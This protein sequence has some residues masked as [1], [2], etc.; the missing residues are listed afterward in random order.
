MKNTAHAGEAAS[1]C[2]CLHP[3]KALLRVANSQGP[4]KAK[5]SPQR[6]GLRMAHVRLLTRNK[7]WEEAGHVTGGGGG[8][9]G[10]IGG[11]G[12]EHQE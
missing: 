10:G 6:P 11:E 7:A 2:C 5:A 12:E 3:P 9:W 4:P 8:G 1:Q